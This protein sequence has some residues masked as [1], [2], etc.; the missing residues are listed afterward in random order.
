MII[1]DIIN[2]CILLQV[3]SK[4]YDRVNLDILK[5]VLKVKKY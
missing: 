1:D 4:A 5:L 2:L 3:Q